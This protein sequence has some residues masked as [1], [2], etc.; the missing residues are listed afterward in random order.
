MMDRLFAMLGVN[1]DE[2]KA[3][4]AHYQAMAIKT[5]EHFNARLDRIEGK[6]DALLE[7]RKQIGKDI[8]HD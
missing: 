8:G 2:I 3:A 1:P 5:A 4:A 7:Q 6:L